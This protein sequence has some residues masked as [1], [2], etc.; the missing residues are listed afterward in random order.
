MRACLIVAVLL[1]A[2][3]ARADDRC[4]ALRVR[5]AREHDRAF[6]WNLAWG[7]GL[8][9]AALVQAGAAPLIGN[10]EQRDTLYVGAVESAIGAGASLVTPLR[11][12]AATTCAD[13][14][15]ALVDAGHRERGAF[16]LDHVGGIVVNLGGALVL[17]HYTTTANAAIAFAIGYSI[18]LVRTYTMPRWAWHPIL[19]LDPKPTV[20]VGVSAR[21]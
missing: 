3:P 14:D 18:A 8:G 4:D 10:R 2:P 1:A 15:A 5:L 16:Y 21:F 20:G 13:L 6:R 17:A 7:V 11:V 12:T 19:A 9:A